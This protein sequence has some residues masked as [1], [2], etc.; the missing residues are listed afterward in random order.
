MNAERTLQDGV[1]VVRLSGL[2]DIR[3]LLETASVLHDSLNSDSREVVLEMS[4]LTGIKTSAINVL[5][6]LQHEL[7]QNGRVL[8]I[9][10]ANETVS[11][12]LQLRRVQDTIWM[13]A[14]LKEA[15]TAHGSTL[16]G[17]V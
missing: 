7:K 9:A 16:D 13:F 14:S 6:E 5:L 1:C 17:T 4:G 15:V 10:A 8:S 11:R 12:S 3:G 2:F